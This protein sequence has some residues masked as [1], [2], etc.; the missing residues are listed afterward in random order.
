MRNQDSEKIDE[1]QEDM[2]ARTKNYMIQY[3]SIGWYF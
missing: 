3:N 1:I 2:A